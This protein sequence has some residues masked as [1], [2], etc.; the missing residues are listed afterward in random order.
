MQLRKMLVVGAMSLGGLA[1]AQT[2]VQGPVTN[3]NNGH[4]YLVVQAA[5]WTQ[6][7]TFAQS[8]GGHL[9]TVEDVLEN[10]WINTNLTNSGTWKLFIGLNDVAVEGTYVWA[11]GSTSAYR[12]WATGE[13]H[14]DDYCLLQPGLGGKWTMANAT[15][16]PYG[17]IELSGAIKVPGD[18]PTIQAAV[19]AAYPGATIEVL[20]GTY[21]GTIEINKPLTLRSVYGAETT[22]IDLAST[23]QVRFVPGAT[24]GTLLDGFTITGAH[25][26]AAFKANGSGVSG[27]VTNCVFTGNHCPN[28]LGG[29]IYLS[30]ASGTM[31]FEDCRI[32]GNSAMLASGVFAGSPSCTGVFVNCLFTANSSSYADVHGCVESQGGTLILRNC[33]VA[34]N[35]QLSHGITAYGGATNQVL[36]HNTIVDRQPLVDLG[37]VITATYSNIA[38]GWAGVGNFDADPKFLGGGNYSLRGDS[39]CIDAGNVFDYSGFGGAIDL[40]GNP[41]AKNDPNVMD[42]G[43]GVPPIDIGAYEFQPLDP[44]CPADFNGDGFVNALDYDEFAEHFEEGC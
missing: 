24:S 27:R 9:A 6:M 3:P 39:P 37:G 17:V 30:N 5:N 42:T 35:N 40:A 18:Y 15:Y 33:T 11:D 41:R 7:E 14:S 44:N 1:S 8:L 32:A 4:R 20:P 26:L 13:P 12:Y 34:G 10:S 28:Q 36:V 23:E 21:T 16:S 38:G 43:V 25:D 31:T 19:A 22:T 29:A 2:I